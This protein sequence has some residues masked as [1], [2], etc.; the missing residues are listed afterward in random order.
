MTTVSTTPATIQNS[1]SGKYAPSTP[2]DG[3]FAHP[4][5][6]TAAIA[7][8]P[9][10]RFEH[11]PLASGMCRFKV[12]SM[13][14]INVTPCRYADASRLGFRV[15]GSE[16]NGFGRTGDVTLALHFQQSAF[17]QR[18]SEET[19]S[20]PFKIVACGPPVDRWQAH[21]AVTIT[22]KKVFRIT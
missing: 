9:I 22:P 18:P 17:I 14:E 2:M 13:V 10:A 15:L 12:V 3:E 7:A 8:A 16:G 5:I 1:Q 20:A 6:G 21:Q 19:D 11:L 4:D